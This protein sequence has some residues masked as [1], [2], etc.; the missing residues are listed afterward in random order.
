MRVSGI[1]SWMRGSSV[2]VV[3]AG[4]VSPLRRIAC[5]SR[6]KREGSARMSGLSVPAHT[7][8]ACAAR[9]SPDAAAARLTK[10]E[11]GPSGGARYCAEGGMAK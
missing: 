9:G 2:D 1:H 3:F 4:P 5:P 10:A 6:D 7:R 8:T 11:P